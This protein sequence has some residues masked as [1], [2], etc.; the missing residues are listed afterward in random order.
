MTNCDPAEIPIPP[1]VALITGSDSDFAE[2]AHI[3]YESLLQWLQ[4]ISTSTQPDILH[5]VPKP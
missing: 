2:A 1:D 3:P 5:D 4:W